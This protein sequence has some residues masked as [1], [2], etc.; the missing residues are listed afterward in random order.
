MTAPRPQNPILEGILREVL[1]AL[2]T[3]LP[4]QKGLR[5]RLEPLFLNDEA[6]REDDLRTALFTDDIQ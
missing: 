3:E 1:D 5:E 6:P 4:D 2:V